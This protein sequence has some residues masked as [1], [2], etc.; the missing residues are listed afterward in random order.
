MI[1]FFHVSGKIFF[2]N[3]ENMIISGGNQDKKGVQTWQQ[4][5]VSHT[6]QALAGI[7]MEER[8]ET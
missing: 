3:R 4:M 2:I 1:A 8:Y 6:G 7:L 5:R